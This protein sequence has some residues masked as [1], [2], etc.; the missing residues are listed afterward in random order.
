MQDL[1]MSQPAAKQACKFSKCKLVQRFLPL[2]NL[3][4]SAWQFAA[5]SRS[6]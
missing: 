5:I 3:L 2:L 4:M 6:V 1:V